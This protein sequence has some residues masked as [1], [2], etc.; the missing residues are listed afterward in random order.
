MNTRG[1]SLDQAPPLSVPVSF[2]LLAPVAILSAGVMLLSSGASLL[3]TRH[4]GATAAL[5]H[6]GTLGLLGSVMLGALYQMIPVVAGAPVPIVRSAHG[7]HAGYVVGVVALVAGLLDGTRWLTILGAVA[8]TLALIVFV[9]AITVALLRAPA[10]TATTRGMMTAV[11][12]LCVALALGATMAY[13][14]GAGIATPW[15]PQFV[16]AH[17]GV[18]LVVW[19]GGLIS[20]VSFQVIPMFY[21]APELGPRH[22]IGLIALVFCTLLALPLALALGAGPGWMAGLMLPGG[23]AVWLL[24][25]MA[26][27]RALRSR[28]RK[29]ADPSLSFWRLGLSAAIASFVVGACAAIWDDPRL[30]LCFGYLLV[31]GWAGSIVHGMLSRIVP[32][33]VWFH[34]F[35]SLVGIVA[36]PPMRRLLPERLSQVGL[37]C[38]L[39]ALV[40][41]LA[42]ITTG[43]DVLAR[44]AGVALIATGCSLGVALVKVLGHRVPSLRGG[45]QDTPQA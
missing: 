15:Y 8:L 27:L 20:A 35:S 43:G 22:Q 13:V 32:F 5:T 42:A 45:S 36:V 26:V 23:A 25:P 28:R 21:L 33:L 18:G 14:R 17:L 11:L 34:R 44:L 38:H 1:L 4:A 31:W 16:L 39:L 10:K 30:G 29:R 9:A 37:A 3:V 24:H 40:L 2:F 6:V 19:V 41:G 7:V 12:G